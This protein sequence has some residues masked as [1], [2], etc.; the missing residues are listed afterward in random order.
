[1]SQTATYKGCPIIWNE[2]F[3]FS[4]PWLVVNDWVAQLIVEGHNLLDCIKYTDSQYEDFRNQLA[5]K[6]AHRTPTSD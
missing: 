3:N 5:A 6:W 4:D 2:N 1:M